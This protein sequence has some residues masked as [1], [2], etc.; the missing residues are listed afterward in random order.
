[1]NQNSISI[2]E[3][4]P[5]W[6]T[7]REKGYA[8]TVIDVRSNEEY[9]DGHVPGAQLLPL[10]TLPGRADEVNK[11]QQIFLICRS[12]MR[13]AQ[14]MDYLSRQCGHSNLV[15]VSGGT[16]AWLKAGYPIEKGVAQ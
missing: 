14:A 9:A 7:A 15:N 6:L 11:E 8:C 5:R 16:M 12:G 13:S 2:N 3:L 1:M 10:D 4:Y